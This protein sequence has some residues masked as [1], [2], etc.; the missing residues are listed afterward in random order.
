M[1]HENDVRHPTLIIYRT[2]IFDL[3]PFQGSTQYM[4]IHITLE[5]RCCEMLPI[6]NN[7]T[8][9]T[10]KEDLECRVIIYVCIILYQLNASIFMF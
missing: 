3:D 8:T 4:N 1:Y 5:F 7:S 9:V 10:A 2:G 6:V